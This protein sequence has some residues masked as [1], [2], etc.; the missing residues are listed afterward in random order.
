MTR[1]DRRHV[2]SHQERADEDATK[3]APTPPDDLLE[4][5][6]AHTG[7]TALSP[8][9]QRSILALTAETAPVEPATWTQLLDA[10]HRGIQHHRND[11]AALPRMLFMRRCERETSLDDIA[12]AIAVPAKQLGAIE[13]GHDRVETLTAAKVAAW[14]LFLDVDAP[15]ARASLTKA[16][17]LQRRENVALAAAA[18]PDAE[19]A[20][21]RFIDEVIALVEAEAGRH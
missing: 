19:D 18:S 3:K 10:A 6:L 15:Q 17:E 21:D 2:D 1:R 9:V 11:S 13:H 7:L 14:I 5:A 20:D 12:A 16:L 4:E 8:E